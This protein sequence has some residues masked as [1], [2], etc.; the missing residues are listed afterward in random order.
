MGLKLLEDYAFIHLH[1]ARDKLGLLLQMVHKLYALVG[2]R[3]GGLHRAR[4]WLASG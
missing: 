1:S 4:L 2:G 3:G